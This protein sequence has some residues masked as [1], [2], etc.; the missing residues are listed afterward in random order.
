MTEVRADVMPG[1]DREPRN[2]GSLS[3]Q[4]KSR[5]IDLPRL[6]RWHLPGLWRL[7]REDSKWDGKSLAVWVVD[8]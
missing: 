6:V 1:R 5:K 2:A 7:R 3:E 8:G 4:Q